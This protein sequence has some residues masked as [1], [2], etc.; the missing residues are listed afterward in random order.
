[1][2]GPRRLGLVLGSLVLLAAACS[3]GPRLAPTA[4]PGASTPPIPVV[5]ASP[6]AAAG[7]GNIPCDKLAPMVTQITGLPI[8]SIDAAPDDCSFNVNPPGD[9]STA[10]FGGIVDIRR[11][12]DEPSDFDTIN[13]GFTGTDGVDV[14]GVGDRARRTKDGSLMYAVHAGHVWAVQQ[15]LLVSGLDLPGNASK[16][17]LAL[18]GVV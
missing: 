5:G 18:F 16:L 2:P 9:S 8:A 3:S 6:A 15:E 17:M 1:V 12:S 14:P 11:E 10:G 4:A 13:K 7:G